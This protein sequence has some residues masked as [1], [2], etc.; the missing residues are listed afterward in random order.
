MESFEKQR[1]QLSLRFTPQ[2]W[3]FV[4]WYADAFGLSINR[5]ITVVIT[6]ALEG[7]FVMAMRES[8]PPAAES[9]EGDPHRFQYRL[10]TELYERI[11]RRIEADRKRKGWRGY[12]LGAEAYTKSWIATALRH[13]FVTLRDGHRYPDLQPPG[14]PFS[15]GEATSWLSD[16]TP[17]VSHRTRQPA[18]PEEQYQRYQESLAGGIIEGEADWVD[19]EGE[20]ECGDN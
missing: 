3:R 10:P 4:K 2:G 12:W 6:N 15:A 8:E 11:V 18:T 20:A 16:L 17:T 9:D 7:R 1:Q 13:A 19:E 14:K 5:W